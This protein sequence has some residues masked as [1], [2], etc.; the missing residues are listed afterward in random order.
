MSFISKVELKYQ[1]EKMGI[2]VAGNY[3]KKKD[4]EKTVSPVVDLKKKVIGMHELIMYFARTSTYESALGLVKRHQEE[5]KED[6]GYNGYWQDLDLE[7]N[8]VIRSYPMDTAGCPNKAAAYDYMKKNTSAVD[9]WADVFMFS[10]TDGTY[11]FLTS[12]EYKGVPDGKASRKEGLRDVVVIK[13]KD[14]YAAEKA[15]NKKYLDMGH[16]NFM[17]YLQDSQEAFPTLEAAKKYIHTMSGNF[18]TGDC[19]AFEVKSPKGWLFAAD[20]HH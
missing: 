17:R 9:R 16:I 4:V 13:A 2:K 18:R 8:N 6:N 3:I 10:M 20:I 7:K 12:S 14:K 11:L 5:D 19:Y 15:F 1:L